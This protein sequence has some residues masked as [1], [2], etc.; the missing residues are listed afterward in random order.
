SLRSAL[1]AGSA[2]LVGTVASQPAGP[3]FSDCGR[4][5]E[6][7]P[8]L[9]QLVGVNVEAHVVLG[10][11]PEDLLV[12]A[13][14]I[15]SVVHVISD[16][17][18]APANMERQFDLATRLASMEVFQVAG[19]SHRPCPGAEHAGAGRCH[20]RSSLR[21]VWHPGDRMSVRGRT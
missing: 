1:E 7:V 12:D 14:P 3:C 15:S 19:Y 4:Q 9:P 2:R 5:D 17:W 8:Q 18:S 20:H 11:L 16:G 21:P 10:A 13:G 6:F